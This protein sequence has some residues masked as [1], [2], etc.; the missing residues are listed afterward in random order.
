MAFGALAFVLSA[1]QVA[2]VADEPSNPTPRELRALE[3]KSRYAKIMEEQTAQSSKLAKEL[4][5]AGD[6]NAAKT[7][8]SSILS[9]RGPLGADRYFPLAEFREDQEESRSPAGLD[10]VRGKSAQKLHDLAV[11]AAKSQQYALALEWLHQVLALDPNHK[12]ARTLLGFV[13]AEG[14]WGTPFAVKMRKLGKVLHPTFGWIDQSWVD[15][16]EAGELPE[17]E[18]AKSVHWISAEEANRLHGDLRN[19]WDIYTEHFHIRSTVPLA[20]VITFGKRLERLYDVFTTITADQLGT[21]LP[22]VR[23]LTIPPL[24]AATRPSKPH[25]ILYVAGKEQYFEALRENQV[26]ADDRS[27]GIYVYGARTSFFY[28]GADRRISDTE[29]LYH[30]ASH[31]LLFELAGKNNHLGNIGEFWVFEG[32]G[33]YFETLITEPEGTILLGGMVGPRIDEIRMRI[34]DRNEFVPIKALVKLNNKRFF[35]VDEYGDVF[36]K[37]NESMALA[38]FLMQSSEGKHRERFLMYLFDA[39]KGRMASPKSR[40]LADR[41]GVPFPKLD[42]QFRAYLQKTQ[43]P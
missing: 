41:L 16:L 3:L 24:K 21:A 13:H 42:E 4:E 25:E 43:K 10:A 7:V 11:E 5:A 30:E 19:P 33:T 31:Q 1:W 40:T 2:A 17:D 39:F 35:A 8:R 37:Y 22:S 27:L 34:L 6:P 28:R 15:P 23:R 14:G 9:S 38:L 18:S 20:D 12:E 29:T 26:K 36:L 32:F